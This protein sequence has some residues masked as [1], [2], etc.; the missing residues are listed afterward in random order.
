[1]RAAT[2]SIMAT[3]QQLR[4]RLARDV[5]ASSYGKV[6]RKLGIHRT[7]IFRI[8]K[9]QTPITDMVA[10]AMGYRRVVRVRFERINEG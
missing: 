2:L 4:E 7:V 3:E 6:G 9:G 10:E 1:M 8:V 5:E